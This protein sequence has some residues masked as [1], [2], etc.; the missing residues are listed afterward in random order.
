MGGRVEVVENWAESLKGGVT[1]N[2]TKKYKKNKTNKN[3][4]PTICVVTRLFFPFFT[5]KRVAPNL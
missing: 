1:E 2:K 5:H 3:Q 4:Q